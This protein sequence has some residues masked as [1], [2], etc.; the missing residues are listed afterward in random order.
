MRRIK[1]AF[2]MFVAT[3]VTVLP[4]PAGAVTKITMAGTQFVPAVATAAVGETVTW[5]NG[6]A[7]D[8]PVVI[9]KHNVTPDPDTATAL[10]FKAFPTSSKLLALG[11]SWSCTGTTSGARCV[12]PDGTLVT[13]KAGTY[14]FKCG[15]HPNQM[16]GILK[17]G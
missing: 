10:G 9:G 13:L 4:S 6:E 7:A 14:A 11:G 12:R 17:I 3:A 16:R 2:T 1:V 8:Y 15:L 5:T